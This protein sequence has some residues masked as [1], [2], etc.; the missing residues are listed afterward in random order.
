MHTHE[1]K[2]NAGRKRKPAKDINRG[3]GVEQR[4]ATSP[5]FTAEYKPELWRSAI[6]IS[7][8]RSEAVADS[9]AL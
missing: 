9:K 5:C 3:D 8:P 2:P 7:I 4:S 1:P 6:P